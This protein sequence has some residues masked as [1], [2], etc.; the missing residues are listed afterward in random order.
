MSK[1][2]SSDTDP[3]RYRI[4]WFAGRGFR[5]A[6]VHTGVGGVPLLLIHGWPETKR[7]YW[8]VIA[9]LASAG[10]EVIVPDLRGYGDSDLGPDGKHDA[11]ASSRDLHAL[12]TEGLEHSEVVVAGGDFGGV[13][14]QDL[15]ARFPGFVDRLVLTNCPLPFE[16][17]AMAGLR[18]RGSPE[19]LDYYRR[20]GT[21]ADALIAELNTSARRRHYVESFYTS[22]F[23]AHPGA[24]TVLDF[25]CAPFDDAERLRATWG[26]YEAR[27]DPVARSETTLM[28][29]GGDT[30]TMVLYGP[31][32]RVVAP[33]FDKM[34]GVV[35]P[36]HVGPFLLRDCG[37]FVPW[38][39]AHAFTSAVTT[40]C[41]DLLAARGESRHASSSTAAATLA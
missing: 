17:E 7:L 33:D 22:R 16:P 32:D 21:D 18:T 35:F 9:P 15:V 13:V 23:W 20:Q 5:Q 4:R 38:E 28:P 11:P 34:A 2:D 25:H 26:A 10:F 29:I 1:S 30:R 40:F 8:R 37:H 36:H 27:F 3:T 19:S 31:S 12:V 39:A 6:F 24:F 41:S 14:A